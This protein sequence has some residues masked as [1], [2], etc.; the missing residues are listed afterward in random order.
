MRKNLKKILLL[1]NIILLGIICYGA[2]MGV[3]KRASQITAQ[4]LAS[5]CEHIVPQ[6]QSGAMSLEQASAYAAEKGRVGESTPTAKVT[7]VGTDVILQ[8][9]QLVNSAGILNGDKSGDEQLNC[10]QMIGA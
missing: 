3:N 10:S 8:S 5:I 6:I 4:R 9:S 2:I 7:R 1:A